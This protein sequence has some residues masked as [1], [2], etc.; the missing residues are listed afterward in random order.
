MRLIT[1]LALAT[2]AAVS[3]VAQPFRNISNAPFRSTCDGPMGALVYDAGRSDDGTAYRQV[4]PSHRARVEQASQAVR[5]WKQR[6][7]IPANAT[8]SIDS[9]ACS[10][11]GYPSLERT[12]NG[13][14]QVSFSF[15]AQS[16]EASWTDAQKA[17]MQ[18]IVNA[19]IAEINA[20][21]GPP[22]WTGTV[23]VVNDDVQ[24]SDRDAVS[25]GVYVVDRN[26]ILFPVYNSPLSVVVNLV[27]MMIHAW[28]GPATLY[29]D[30][31]EEGMARAATMVIAPRVARKAMAQL[32]LTESDI[33][34]IATDTNFHALPF[35][36]LLN[37]P[38][39]AHSAFSAPNLRDQ[40]IYI[41]QIGGMWLPR[42]MMAGSAWLKIALDHPTV[43][44]AFNDVLYSRVAADPGVRGRVGDL[45]QILASVAPTVEGRP[46]E[47]W[48]IRQH[49]LNN[50]I[51]AGRKAYAFVVPIRTS[52]NLGDTAAVTVMYWQTGADGTETPISGTCY[53][54]YWS[55][56]LA[57]PLYL[58][59][60]YE[61]VSIEEGEGNVAP[62]FDATSIGG[63]QRVW[64]EFPVAS[65]STRLAFPAG[66]L[67]SSAAPNTLCGVA[68]GV[69]TGT[70]EVQSAG[71]TPVSLPL[72]RGGFGGALPA[73]AFQTPARY[74]FTVKNAAGT[75]V[76]VQQVNLGY[77]QA[78]VVLDVQEV[79]TVSVNIPA[80][81][82][83]MGLPCWP[84]VTDSAA[85]L[86]VP[87]NQLLLA[88]WTPELVQ[89]D[90]YVLY[91][92]TPAFAP[93]RGYWLKTAAP[94]TRT[95]V[96]KV[97][98]AGAPIPL[99]YG[100]NMLS[101]PFTTSLARSQLQVRYRNDNPVNYSEAVT[102]QYVGP[103]FRYNPSTGALEQ[104]ETLAP[105][106]AAWVRV[107][108]AEGVT[109][110]A[111]AASRQSREAGRQT[112][113]DGWRLTLTAD[114]GTQR[115]S[116]VVGGS[117]APEAVESPPGFESVLAL[118]SQ[119]AA[120]GRLATD[121]RSNAPRAMWRM[122]L[123][124]SASENVTLRWNLQGR[125]P[126]GARVFIR[127]PGDSQKILL[128]GQSGEVTLRGRAAGDFVEVICESVN[129]FALRIQ[130]VRA[131]RTRSG[132]A[133]VSFSI[134]EEAVVRTS[135]V[136]SAGRTIR[137]VG[138][139]TVG[140]GL[141]SVQ[142][143]GRTDAGTAVSAGMYL[144]RVEA[145]NEAGDRCQSTVPVMVTR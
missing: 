119:P 69:D 127:Q 73:P 24:M 104:T 49:V 143:D 79:E 51:T 82:S 131:V 144:M 66:Y 107:L 106:E 65:Q 67:G 125:L 22:G 89:E 76:G 41:G 136:D 12:R 50:S 10:T 84:Y 71:M 129:L 70:V 115:A 62:V 105:L 8:V 103:L 53:P 54:A 29:Y 112:V 121:V 16:G 4:L 3:A 43:F 72:V 13:I 102:R 77:E 88:R 14:N 59:E 138:S 92:N 5:L 109:V 113:S 110:Y 26:V 117:T 90:R 98:Q 9:M 52:G 95:V 83:L 30:A 63:A 80:G 118:V 37:Q 56:D 64:M 7:L 140:R 27:H 108:V 81:L 36:D 25:G 132:G 86:G 2:L 120:G 114:T 128:V 47:D 34:Q 17:Y 60:Q 38:S 93:G 40:P 33:W 101:N 44:S 137:T 28:H 15:E 139:A 45:R 133:A 23:R 124:Q 6:G 1:C 97:A 74:Q 91:P 20:T 39:L 46:L 134:N 57:E 42:Y 21:Y 87:A 18:V 61:S 58:G 116:A 55:Y 99:A 122:A 35:Y 94:I 123:E 141:Q 31:W 145:W 78:F 85:L 111:R 126:R 96:G 130:G 142:W 11:S 68:D 48:F 135:I 32:G 100:W 75:V 19:A